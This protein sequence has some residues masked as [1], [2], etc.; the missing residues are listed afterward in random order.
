MGVALARSGKSSAADLPARRFAELSRPMQLRNGGVI[1]Q[2]V[3][4]Y[5]SWGR[6]NEAHDNVVLLFTGLSPS[7]HAASSAEDAKPGWWESMIGE[8]RPI[9][10]G[11]FFVVCVNSIGS[12][13]GSSSPASL[14]KLTGRPYGI[15][16]PQIAIEDIAAGGHEALR[17]LGI[18]RVACVIGS[19]LGGMV[20]LAYCAMY[21]DAVDGLASIS[22]A[23]RA[24]PFAI[25]QRSLQREIV[26]SDPAW[27]G[28]NYEPGRGPKLGMRLARKLG[29]ITYRSAE[30][31]QQRFG[32]RRVTRAAGLAGDMT[33]RQF[34]V[35]SYL[36][37]QAQRFSDTFDANCYLYLSSAMDEF[38]LADH[39]D[40]S[41]SAA[42]EA[43]RPKRSLVLGVETDMLFP[44][45][46]Q[47]EIAEG[48]EAAG[49]S[50]VFH[51]FPSLQGHD[52]F[53]VDLDR[54]EPAIADF[55][56]SIESTP[57]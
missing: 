47:R 36:E 44:I 17:T 39:A 41:L 1:E 37:H 30:E 52:A 2:P 49:R 57:L 45:E 19:S 55:M 43:F 53:L 8:G 9:D 11:R 24:T 20:V 48:L 33:R 34:E 6:L 46:Q 42:F 25:A 14:N 35:E 7:A 26:R 56:A 16:F 31:W 38:D 15:R 50:V 54:F 3:V 40:G 23:A 4:A 22:G 32:R 5:E 13:Y 51:A 10:T 27:R 28:G 12:P 29:T 18:D 21:P